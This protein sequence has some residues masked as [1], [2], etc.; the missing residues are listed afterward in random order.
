M[1]KPLV[2]YAWSA[3]GLDLTL[4]NRLASLR[5]GRKLANLECHCVVTARGLIVAAGGGSAIDCP[6]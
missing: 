2:R 1:P 5:P 3:E 6:E 4:Y